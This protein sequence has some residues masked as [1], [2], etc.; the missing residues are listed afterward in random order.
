MFIVLNGV[1]KGRSYIFHSKG[2]FFSFVSL[3]FVFVLLFSF[4]VSM[5]SGVSFFTF[6]AEPVQVGTEAELRVAVNNAVGPAVIVLTTDISLKGS[7]LIIS[8]G[9]DITLV[10]NNNVK[11]FKLIGVM[12]RAL[13]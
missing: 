6:G 13:F 4:V 9:K 12:G 3:L 1:S 5:F 10:S 8:S 2:A 11:F 7:A